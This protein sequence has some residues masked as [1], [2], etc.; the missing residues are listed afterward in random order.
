MPRRNR[1]RN[2]KQAHR[3]ARLTSSQPGVTPLGPVANPATSSYRLPSPSAVRF[4]RH[5][6]ARYSERGGGNPNHDRAAGEL[7][8]ARD[9]GTR[10]AIATAKPDWVG[11]QQRA[12]NI[13]QTIAYMIVDDR[14]CFPLVPARE[15]GAVL[16]TTCIV[17]GHLA[18]EETSHVA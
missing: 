18:I 12:K 5:A 2:R 6:V 1:P 15:P 11:P 14:L 17:R 16:A 4:S 8:V 9:D 13:A 10:T 7:V 3:G